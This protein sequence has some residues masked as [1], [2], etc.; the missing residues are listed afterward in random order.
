MMSR[1][2][3]LSDGAAVRLLEAGPRE[4]GRRDAVLLIHGVGMRAEAW[5]PQIDTL[6]QHFR[7]IAVDMPGHGNSD[8]L[9]ADARL[10]DFVAWAARV[11]EALDLGPVNLAGHS[12]GALVAAMD[13]R[14]L[15]V[16]G[17]GH[18]P[19]LMVGLL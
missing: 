1:T 19:G 17:G 10:P 9:P 7:V 14:R 12:M 6:S 8:R 11:V 5:A 4:P 16:S 15:G 18:Y 3:R 13:H 2:L